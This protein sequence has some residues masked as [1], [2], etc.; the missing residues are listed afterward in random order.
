MLFLNL[1]HLPVDLQSHDGHVLIKIHYPQHVFIALL[2]CYFNPRKILITRCYFHHRTD[3][4]NS[5]LILMRWKTVIYKFTIIPGKIFNV[6][7][8]FCYTISLIYEFRFLRHL[9]VTWMLASQTS[10]ITV[11]FAKILFFTI[12]VQRI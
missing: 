6:S 7:N 12:M 8:I 1:G 11:L 9:E 2:V 4:L 10:I 3:V 5:L